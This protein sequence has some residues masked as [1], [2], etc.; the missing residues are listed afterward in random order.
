LCNCITSLVIPELYQ[1]GSTAIKRVL[2]G[3]HAFRRYDEVKIWP[4]CFTGMQVIVNRTTPPH[5]DES[6]S[7]TLYNL[8][9]S[10]STHSEARII[11]RDIRLE[12]SYDPRTVVMLSGKVLLYEVGLWEAGERICVAYMMKDIV[13][14]RLDVPRLAWP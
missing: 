6:R 7:S 4:S 11:C 10:A 2:E 3:Q 5:K 14:D 9:V 8:L 1:C 13:H 12:L